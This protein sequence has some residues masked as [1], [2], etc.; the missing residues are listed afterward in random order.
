MPRRNRKIEDYVRLSY[1]AL[2]FGFKNMTLNIYQNL[3]NKKNEEKFYH[4][5]T[6]IRKDAPTATKWFDEFIE[7]ISIPEFKSLA[8]NL[9][10]EAKKKTDQ[11]NFDMSN[12]IYRIR[13]DSSGQVM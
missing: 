13:N 12:L 1:I 10:K 8:E 4:F 7:T 3:G 9:W 6:E 11:D 2:A 5:W